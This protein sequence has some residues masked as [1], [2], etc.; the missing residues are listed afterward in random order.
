MQN[1]NEQEN[2]FQS[3]HPPVFFSIG[4]QMSANAQTTTPFETVFDA[5]KKACEALDGG[6]AS[7]EQLLAVS[8]TLR[9]AAPIPLIVKQT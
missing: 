2:Y 5:C 4:G 7:G 6:F 1:K 9:D 8:K 3:I